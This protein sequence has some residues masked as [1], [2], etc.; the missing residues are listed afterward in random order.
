MVIDHGNNF[1]TRYAHMG[2]GNAGAYGGTAPSWQSGKGNESSVLVNVGDVV[3]AGDKLGYI[4][5]T[6]SSTGAHAHIELIWHQLVLMM[7]LTGS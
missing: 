5:T 4:G 3:K 7:E 2:Y 6:G 1:Y